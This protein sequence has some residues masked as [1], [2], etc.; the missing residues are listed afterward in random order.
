MRLRLLL[1]ICIAA[2]AIAGGA[3][4]TV[5]AAEPQKAARLKVEF[6]TKGVSALSYGTTNLLA[7][8]S[9]LVERAAFRKRD[10]SEAVPPL[11]PDIKW[12]ARRRVLT[13]RLPRGSVTC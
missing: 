3:R 1:V 2:V 10:G 8:G 6:N 7:D 9:F 4:R 5:G 13:T 12:D 11:K